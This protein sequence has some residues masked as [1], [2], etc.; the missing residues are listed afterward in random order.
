M[1]ISSK[2]DFIGFLIRYLFLFSISTGEAGGDRNILQ[3]WYIF[4]FSERYVRIE[5]M[6]DFLLRIQKLS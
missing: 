6:Y 4:I 2:T 5:S 3:D 1:V